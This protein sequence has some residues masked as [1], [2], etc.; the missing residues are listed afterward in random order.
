MRVARSEPF[1]YPLHK[2][3]RYAALTNAATFDTAIN[4]TRKQPKGRTGTDDFLESQR[5]LAEA[6]ERPLKETEYL[7]RSP[8]NAKRLMESIAEL[9]AGGGLE[10]TFAE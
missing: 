7:L 5:V 1:P 9:E 2:G 6:E 10:R 8:A 4:M 3:S